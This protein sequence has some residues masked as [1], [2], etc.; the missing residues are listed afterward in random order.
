MP[1]PLISTKR[2]WELIMMSELDLKQMEKGFGGHGVDKSLRVMPAAQDFECGAS[3]EQTQMFCEARDAHIAVQ[4]QLRENSQAITSLADILR[5]SPPRLVITYGRGSS[6]HAA[7]FLRYLIEMR[8]HLPTA[9]VSPSIASIYGVQLDLRDAL[10]IAISQSGRSPDVIAGVTK[11]KLAGARVVTIVNDVQ[12]PLAMLADHVIPLHAAP[13]LSVAATKSYIASI[14]AA[15]SIV[16]H[17]D[18]DEELI[19]D[20]EQ[21]PSLLQEAWSIDWSDAL[22]E[23]RDVTNCY[24]AARGLGLAIAQEAALKLKE[25]CGVHAEAFSSAE[26]EHGPMSLIQSLPVFAFVQSDQAQESMTS[27][28]E[29]I[30]EKMGNLIKFGGVCHDKVKFFPSIHANPI[31]EPVLLIQSFYRLV[32][33][34]AQLRGIDPDRPAHLSKV[35]RT[36]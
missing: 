9:S 3:V 34:L 8:L 18:S 30:L 15:I 6:D 12:S 21:L 31:L 5:K 11:A 16:A 27:F 17:W 2:V 28:I 7:T 25:V 29:K 1:V 20:M 22:P 35:T 24:T 36:L 33:Q 14:A 4:R 13:E 19:R 10:C 26:L 32:D 23:F